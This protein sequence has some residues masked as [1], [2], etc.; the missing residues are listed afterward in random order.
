VTVRLEEDGPAYTIYRTGS[1]QIRGAKTEEDLD[2]AERRFR[3][4]LDEL[5]IE[6]DDYEFEHATSVFMESL[7]QRVDLE[8]AMIALGLEVTEYE[9]E[10]FPGLIYRP[11]SFEVTLLVFASGKIIVG[12]TTD[13]NQALDAVNH[14]REQLSTIERV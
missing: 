14:L 10:Q 12:G 8:T 9:P 5:D 13:R 4:A 3:E 1:F 7:D 2:S 11:S 6:V